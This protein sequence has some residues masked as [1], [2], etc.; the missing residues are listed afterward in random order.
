MNND[1]K[2]GFISCSEWAIHQKNC[3][4]HWFILIPINVN[5]TLVH[6]L[7]C[8]SRTFE[9]TSCDSAVVGQCA[10]ILPPWKGAKGSKECHMCYYFSHTILFTN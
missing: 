2:L 10:Y 4:D 8:T 1:G 6:E 7:F 9:D 5:E 3:W